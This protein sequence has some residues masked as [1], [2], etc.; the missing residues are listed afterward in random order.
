MRNASPEN[1]LKV[2]PMYLET[3]FDGST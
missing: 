3:T 1:I 2:S